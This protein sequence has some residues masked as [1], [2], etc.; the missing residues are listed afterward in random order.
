[1]EE[2]ILEKRFADVPEDYA[3][4]KRSKVCVIPVPYDETVTYVK[5]A[6]KGPDAIIEASRNM[7][8]FDYELQAETY[9]VGIYTALPIRPEPGTPPEEVVKASEEIISEIFSVGKLPVI[10]GGE[11]S[12]SAGA[13]RAAKKTFPDVSVLY[14]DAH[15]DLRNE[16]NGSKY[17]HACV[18][19][20]MQETCRVVEAGVR[21]VSK[22]EKDFLNSDACNVKII[23]VYD[24]LENP[25]WKKDASNML[26]DNV[27]VS[28]D[29][30]VF[31]PS[32][33]PSVGTPEPGGLGWYEFIDLLK[34][35]AK[36]KNIIGFDVVE[37]SPKEGNVAPDFLAAKLIYRLIGYIFF[38]NKR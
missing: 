28:I 29:L 11:H 8:V 31:D 2:V 34:L 6:S 21:S 17:N 15:C 18:A 27:Y 23:S 30:D 9:K 5:G 26:S 14:L 20:R 38:G 22:E 1:M 35:V 37:L 4:F 3:G 24:I 32:V 12:V 36:D 19:R 33:M 16:Y 13:V 7:E 10:L 25:M